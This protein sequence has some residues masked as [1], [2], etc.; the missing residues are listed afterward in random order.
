MAKPTYFNLNPDEY[1][2]GLH[3]YPFAV[4]LDRYNGNCNTLD[5]PSY[6]ICVPNKTKDL[7]LHVFNMI[8]GIN[9]SKTIKHISC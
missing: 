2:K 6:K 5:H 8:T 3:Y 1:I 9:E 4:N 7:N